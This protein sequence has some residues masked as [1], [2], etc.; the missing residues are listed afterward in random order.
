MQANGY[1]S[2]PLTGSGSQ[3]S[4]ATPFQ[5]ADPKYLGQLMMN[6][7]KYLEGLGVDPTGATTS[8]IQETKYSNH[9]QQQHQELESKYHSNS[10]LE[11]KYHGETEYQGETKYLQSHDKHH[12]Q[13]QQYLEQLA[14]ASGTMKCR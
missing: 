7:P 9:L 2:T 1:P 14:A 11:N 5:S 12:Q 6:D 13:Q 8:Q 3:G 4:S 10:G